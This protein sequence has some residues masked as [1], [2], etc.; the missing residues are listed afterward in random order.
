MLYPTV[1]LEL[2]SFRESFCLQVV[3]GIQI[4]FTLER[5]IIFVSVDWIPFG[6]LLDCS[7]GPT[8][9][10]VLRRFNSVQNGLILSRLVTLYRLK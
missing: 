2:L 6:M 10:T 7:K 1:N 4:I 9:S 3:A 8:L 5:Y